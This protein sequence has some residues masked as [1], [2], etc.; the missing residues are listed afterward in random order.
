[1][2]TEWCHRRSQPRFSVASQVASR[3]SALPVALPRVGLSRPYGVHGFASGGSGSSPRCAIQ[4]RSGVSAY[5]APTDPH[6]QPS[7]LTPSG[8]SGSGCGQLATGSYGPNSSCPPRSWARRSRRRRAVSSPLPLSGE[9]QPATATN[10]EMM[11][12]RATMCDD[13]FVR[14]VSLLAALYWPLYFF[15]SPGAPGVCWEPMNSFRP[16]GRVTSR[17]LARRE[18]SRAW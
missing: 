9:L 7:C 5:T 18:P 4:M 12:A 1:M 10:A 3:P 2:N 17:P 8:P 6:V 14:I 15:C 13:L 16:S 11:T